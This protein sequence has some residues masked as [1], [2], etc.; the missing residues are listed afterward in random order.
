[1]VGWSL[2]DSLTQQLTRSLTD[3]ISDERVRLGSAALGGCRRV[4]DLTKESI[5]LRLEIGDLS[6]L[7]PDDH[8]AAAAFQLELFLESLDLTAAR[9]M[10]ALELL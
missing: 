4:G 9:G 2:F 5:E 7:L 1:M 6:I 10:V 3:S 8:L